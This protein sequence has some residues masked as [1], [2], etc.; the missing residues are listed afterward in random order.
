MFYVIPNC[1]ALSVLNQLE[2]L[3]SDM[4]QDVSRLPATLARVPP[5]TQRLQMSERNILSRLVNPGTIPQVA[6]RQGSSAAAS[7][8]AGGSS[9]AAA[10]GYVTQTSGGFSILPT[11]TTTAASLHQQ[12]QANTPSVTAGTSQRGEWSVSSSHSH[13]S[14]SSGSSSHHTQPPGHHLLPQGK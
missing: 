14:G 11:S 5:V 3:L 7:T 9:S 10:T 2:E 8:A 4:K 6:Q 1:F 12:A 13:S